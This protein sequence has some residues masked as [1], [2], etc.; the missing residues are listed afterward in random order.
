MRINRRVN[1]QRCRLE[2]KFPIGFMVG[3]IAPESYECQRFQMANLWSLVWRVF[4]KSIPPCAT[5]AGIGSGLPHSPLRSL[6]AFSI[7]VWTPVLAGT[8]IKRPHQMLPKPSCALGCGRRKC[9]EQQALDNSGH[10]SVDS[11]ALLENVSM[12]CARI[13]LVRPKQSQPSWSAE[14]ITAL[15]QRE[16][17]LSLLT[18]GVICI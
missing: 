12:V 13:A 6:P 7:P 15:V 2:N 5:P 1:Q 16:S 11:G 4:M 10:Q 18:P 9:A 17:P 8:V 3:Y 14:R